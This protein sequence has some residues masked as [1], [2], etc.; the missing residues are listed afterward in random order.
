MQTSSFCIEEGT[1]SQV[2][3]RIEPTT[4]SSSY[5]LD[6]VEGLPVARAAVDTAPK[7]PA[8]HLARLKEV[9]QLGKRG[10]MHDHNQ[11]L[12][13]VQQDGGGTWTTETL[14]KNGRYTSLSDTQWPPQHSCELN[15]DVQACA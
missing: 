13:V 14:P 10:V 1:L 4:S 12:T 11:N 9:Y 7:D 5:L 8:S 2:Y 6:G 15:G 3:L